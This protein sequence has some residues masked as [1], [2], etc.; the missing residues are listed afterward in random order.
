MSSLYCCLATFCAVY[1]VIT[2]IAI[3]QVVI[4]YRVQTE[5]CKVESSQQEGEC[6]FQYKVQLDF[7]DDSTENPPATEIIIVVQPRDCKPPFDESKEQECSYRRDGSGKRI[8]LQFGRPWYTQ[9]NFLSFVIIN[10]FNCVLIVCCC[11][12]AGGVRNLCDRIVFSRQ[13]SAP[14]SSSIGVQW[15]RGIRSITK[16]GYPKRKAL[17]ELEA[18]DAPSCWTCA[19]CLEE[20]HEKQSDNTRFSKLP[21]EHVF[22]SM[23]INSWIAKGNGSCPLCR[24]REGMVWCFRPSLFHL[25][26]NLSW[27]NRNSW[28]KS[29]CTSWESSKPNGWLITTPKGMRLSIRSDVIFASNGAVVVVVS[30]LFKFS[31]YRLISV[32]TLIS[33]ITLNHTS[34]IFRWVPSIDQCKEHPSPFAYLSRHHCTSKQMYGRR[35]VEEYKRGEI[36]EKCTWRLY[37]PKKSCEDCISR[38]RADR[39]SRERKEWNFPSHEN[40]P[41]F[42]LTKAVLVKQGCQCSWRPPLACFRT[43]LGRTWRLRSWQLQTSAV[44]HG[45]QDTWDFSVACVV[46]TRSVRGVRLGTECARGAEHVVELYKPSFCNGISDILVLQSFGGL[47]MWGLNLILLPGLYCGWRCT[48][49]K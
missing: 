32:A 30:D 6:Q 34:Y 27:R 41:S 47:Q 21:C 3:A 48:D 39:T 14:P 9:Y 4:S 24:S 12:F 36:L 28:R 11:W 19:I 40:R 33:V 49:N 38:R 2:C 1:T 20:R 37:Q 8:A 13:F 31:L 18:W 15:P 22:H 42:S 45:G 7:E 10:G 25:L 29:T 26:W 35:W 23:C 46:F 43:T 16:D 5:S 44:I 17:D